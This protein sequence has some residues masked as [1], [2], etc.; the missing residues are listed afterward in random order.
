VAFDVTTAY[1]NVLLARASRRVQE[2]AVRLAESILK[3]TQARREGGTADRD[4]VLR[5]EVQVAASR[6]GLVSARETELDALARLNN[7]LGRNAA[8]PIQVLD[9][10]SASDASPTLV[11]WLARAADYRPEIG[12]VR[13]ALVAAQEGVGVAAAAFKPRIYARASV[14]RV[15]GAN[16]LTGWQEGAGLHFE[17]PLYTGGRLRGELLAAQAEVRATLADVQAVLDGISL[18]VSLAYRRVVA[19]AELVEL[20][21]VAVAEAE[22]GLRLVRVKYRNSD[23]IL[24]DLVDVETARTRAQQDLYLAIYAQLAALAQMNYALGL[25]QCDSFKTADA[26]SET[27][28]PEQRAPEE[29]PGLQALPDVK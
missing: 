2:D 6:S 27:E 26:S 8:S 15:D 12:L 28:K 19:A 22:E 21:R 23:A 17:T 18:E 25:P 10:A 20:A 1:V 9:L 7:T 29:P 14:G 13:Q 16:V 11:E 5:A 4:E 24:T 3:D